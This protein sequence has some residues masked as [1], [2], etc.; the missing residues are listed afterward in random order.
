MYFTSCGKE[1]EDK[2]ADITTAYD[3]VKRMSGNEKKGQNSFSSKLEQALE[4]WVTVLDYLSREEKEN[5]REKETRK[6][7]IY[8]KRVTTI[9]E[10]FA[11]DVKVNIDQ[12]L[13]SNRQHI[14]KMY[15]KICT[16]YGAPCLDSYD[17]SNP[18]PYE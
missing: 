6:M 5:P 7:D 18:E 8:R 4:D 15:T 2:M 3:T 14:H 11:P 13:K 1:C 16:K 12:L 9:Y 10:K 17:G